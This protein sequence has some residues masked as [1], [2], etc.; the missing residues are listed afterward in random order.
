[1][2]IKNF[3]LKNFINK[4]N[5]FLIYGENAADIAADRMAAHIDDQ[6]SDEDKSDKSQ[7]S[8]K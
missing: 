1:M 3:E 5:L 6:P 7:Y 8:F 4:C 2:I